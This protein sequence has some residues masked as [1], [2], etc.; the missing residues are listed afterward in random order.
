[1]SAVAATV[2]A[3]DTPINSADA[4]SAVVI[5]RIFILLKIWLL[6]IDFRKSL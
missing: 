3:K 5:L 6:I 4:V 1:V 2:H